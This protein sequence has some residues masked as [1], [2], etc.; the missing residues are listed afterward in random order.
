MHYKNLK[1]TIL[2]DAAHFGESKMPIH[3]LVKSPIF[4]VKV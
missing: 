4:G 1:Y 2:R 3:A